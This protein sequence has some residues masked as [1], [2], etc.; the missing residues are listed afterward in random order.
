[1]FIKLYWSFWFCMILLSE[2][3]CLGVIR[4]RRVDVS[5]SIRVNTRI[6]LAYIF[7]L[8]PSTRAGCDKSSVFKRNTIRLNSEFSFSLSGRL[9]KA[10]EQSLPSFFLLYG[11]IDSVLSQRYR[12]EFP[13]TIT[14][15]LSRYLYLSGNTRRW[16]W[17]LLK[18]LAP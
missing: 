13:G 17:I 12:C 18:H 14:A 3:I 9:T 6:R 2:C 1:M 15:M 11:Y 4:H 5:I 10:K 7:S 8:D 16:K